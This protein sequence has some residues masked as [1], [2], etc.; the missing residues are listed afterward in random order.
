MVCNPEMALAHRMRVGLMIDGY[1][2]DPRELWEIS[3]VRDY[4]RKLFLE[5]PFV[6]LLAHPEFSL[7]KLLFACWIFEPNEDLDS[8]TKAREFEFLQR[9]FAGANDVAYQFCISPE[10]QREAEKSAMQTLYPDFSDQEYDTIAMRS[11]GANE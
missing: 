9:C 10:S 1:D 4:V 11:D 5:C 2:D 7:L 8:A 6:I 3:E